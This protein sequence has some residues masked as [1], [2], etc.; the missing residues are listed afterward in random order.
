MVLK[1]GYILKT[2]AIVK[3]P[4]GF[5]NIPFDSILILGSAFCTQVLV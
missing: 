2:V 1:F 5:E 3:A 4:R